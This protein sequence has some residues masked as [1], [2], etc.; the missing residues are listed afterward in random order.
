MKKNDKVMLSRLRDLDVFE[1]KGTR[2]LVTYWCPS[3]RSSGVTHYVSEGGVSHENVWDYE[4]CEVTYLGRGTLRI[5]LDDE[6][7]G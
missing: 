1:W 3:D 7:E 6:D 4:S 2:N 5:R